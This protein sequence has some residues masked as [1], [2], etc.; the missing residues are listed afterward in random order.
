MGLDS[1]IPGRGRAYVWF[2][3]YLILP[4]SNES[5]WYETLVL[6]V[7]VLVF[8]FCMGLDSIIPGGGRAYVW[9][10]GYLIL[11]ASNESC[12]IH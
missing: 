6:V 11:P 10:G 9:F 7:H 3:G 12:I 2:G 4:A 5:F 1:I 8:F